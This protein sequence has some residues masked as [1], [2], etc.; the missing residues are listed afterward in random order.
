MLQ[1]ADGQTPLHKALAQVRD[2]LPAA[3]LQQPYYTTSTDGGTVGTKGHAEAARLLQ[4]AFP[5]A[6][7]L[8]DKRV[9]PLTSKR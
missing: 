7:K 1:D 5:A 2:D 4:E 8:R 6:C 3:V 9:I